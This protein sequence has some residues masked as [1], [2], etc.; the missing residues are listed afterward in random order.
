MKSLT[1]VWNN[2]VGVRKVLTKFDID[3][4]SIF[5]SESLKCRIPILYVIEMEKKCKVANRINSSYLI[6][7]SPDIISEMNNF[8]SVVGSFTP[9]V[10]RDSSWCDLYPNGR[11]NVNLLRHKIDH[12]PYP[13]SSTFFWLKA[14]PLKVACFVWRATMGKIPS[15]LTLQNR[16]EVERG[17]HILAGCSF[18]P[19]TFEWIFRWCGIHVTQFSKVCE[20]IDYATRCGN[21]PKNIKLFL[22][23]CYGTMWCI[24]KALFNKHKLSPTKVGT[25]L[26][27]WSL[28]GSNNWGKLK[29]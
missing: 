1:G 3:P 20:V 2:I 21:C 9:T 14:V 5:S 29:A 25:W 26:N 27:P 8:I 23:I 17:D 18:A 4:T 15:S 28:C 6:G 22:S 19:I 24:G 16:G 11:Y 7:V 13:R 12:T 10:A